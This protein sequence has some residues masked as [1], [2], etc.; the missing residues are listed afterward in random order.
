MACQREIDQTK[1]QRPTELVATPRPPVRLSNIA[2]PTP[3]DTSPRVSRQSRSRPRSQTVVRGRSKA[4][5]RRRHP[6][7]GD[8]RSVTRHK[9][10]PIMV[11]P[12]VTIPRP[13]V[14]SIFLS[15]AEDLS[16]S[17]PTSQEP[18]QTVPQVFQSAG[19]A[20]STSGSAHTTPQRGIVAGQS[21]PP[22]D[23]RS[24]SERRRVSIQ[25]PTQQNVT[26]GGQHP[27][28]F[29]GRPFQLRSIS[30]EPQLPPGDFSPGISPG[31]KSTRKIYLLWLRLHIQVQ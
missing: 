6:D 24:Q 25:T 30:A 7:T 1:E 9:A 17:C 4:D 15:G 27:G 12:P 26:E 10:D 20:L 16:S 13:T 22:R 5:K 11:M 2:P 21:D 18:A 31:S 3:G 28:M 8:R 19:A 23:P 14:A 29:T